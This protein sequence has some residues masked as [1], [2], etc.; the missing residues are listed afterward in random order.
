MKEYIDIVREALY[1]ID[2]LRASVEFD[3]EYMEGALGFIN[4]LDS[5]VRSLLH[6][7]ESGSYEFGK[8]ELPFIEIVR[9]VSDN[10][11]PFKHLFMRIEMTHKQGLEQEEEPEDE[12]EGD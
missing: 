2:E 9:N 3:E 4:D 8:G 7:L 1:E 11:L 5:G 12:E 6:S 10:L